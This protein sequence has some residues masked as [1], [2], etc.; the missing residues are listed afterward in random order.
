MSSLP[1]GSVRAHFYY[2]TWC[3]GSHGINTPNCFAPAAHTAQLEHGLTKLTP[4]L[5]TGGGDQLWRHLLQKDVVNNPFASF[6]ISLLFAS[7]HACRMRAQG[8]R[9]IYIAC[10]NAATAKTVEGEPV[11]FHPIQ[12]LLEMYGVEVRNWSDNSVREYEHEYAIMSTL[13]PGPGSFFVSLD[14]L[15]HDGFF[16]LYP[17]F[18][19]ANERS[20]PRLHLTVLDLRKYYFKEV[21]P[22]TDEKTR[23]T[24]QLVSSFTSCTSGG[25]FQY[26]DM[27]YKHLLAAILG[28]QKRSINDPALHK[29]LTTSPGPLTGPDSQGCTSKST[30]SNI[31]EFAQ[32]NGL[33]QLL[34]NAGLR[35]SNVQS[36]LNVNSAS[37]ETEK[38]EW[39]IWW[40]ENMDEYRASNPKRGVLQ[41]GKQRYER[42]SY[43]RKH[44]VHKSYDRN[45]YDRKTYDRKSYVH[46]NYDP[47]GNGPKGHGSKGYD[48]KRYDRSRS[49]APWDRRREQKDGQR[50]QRY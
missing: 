1:M 2:R 3:D 12:S 31:D 38:G 34:L 9:N 7:Q 39:R 22:L 45:S 41:D 25:T 32:Y 8:K 47:N 37:V 48:R 4:K 10:V 29:L 18:Q 28:L 11:T 43:D 6:T 26:S 50:K 5:F 15:I 21:R 30:V 49:P 33:V 19:V 17:E 14:T 24:I 36:H 23:L 27:S 40:S 13:V 44:Y 16:Q 42:K 46:K 35:P 20:D